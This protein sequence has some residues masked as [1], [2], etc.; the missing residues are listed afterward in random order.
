MKKF[1]KSYEVFFIANKQNHVWRIPADEI[2]KSLTS[3]MFIVFYFLKWRSMFGAF[4][5]AFQ[6]ICTLIRYQKYQKSS[7]TLFFW[8]VTVVQLVWRPLHQEVVSFNHKK[9]K[10]FILLFMVACLSANMTS[11]Q[12]TAT[13]DGIKYYLEN[14]EATIMVQETSLSGDIV[15]PS[16]VSYNGADYKVTNIT[17]SAFKR[18][19]IKI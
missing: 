19:M 8:C 7:A 13:I 1:E 16:T 5:I 11:A 18:T 9:M 4:M 3:K 6:T 2:P 12:E 10:K 15:I 14:G 17:S